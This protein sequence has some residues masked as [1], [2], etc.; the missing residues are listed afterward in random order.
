MAEQTGAEADNTD[1]EDHGTP[2][3]PNGADLISLPVGTDGDKVAVYWA[4]NPNNEE[5]KQAYVMIHGKMKDGNAY[6]TTMNDILT[7][8][9]EDNYPGVDENAIVV[10]PQFYSA[11]LNSGQYK[12]DELAWDDVNAWQAGEAAIHPANAKESSFDVL[13]AFVNE[14]N[15]KTKYPAMETLVFVGHGGGGQLMTRYAIV[16]KDAPA[17]LRMRWIVGDPSSQPY[18]TEDRPSVDSGEK[19]PTKD[20]CP[21]Y[22][23]WR[24]GFTNF[25][26]TLED[27]LKTPQD[28]F[29]QTIKRD[30][31][32]VVGNDD[33]ESGGDQYCMAVM[34]GG[35]PRRD[36]NLIWWRYL[37]TLARTAEDLT[38]FPGSFENLPDWSNISLNLIQHRLTVVEDAG[39]SADEVFG[40][41]VGRAVLFQDDATTLP[42]GWRPNGWNPNGNGRKVA[43]LQP[44]N[45]SSSSKSS[46]SAS[47]EEDSNTTS[48]ATLLVPP[49][50]AAIVISM[51]VAT[52]F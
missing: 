52:L 13:D 17:G 4:A 9:L 47:Q 15:D 27:G 49:T 42:T 8:A 43:A 11:K 46:S 35:T 21:L 33:T 30:V 41:D 32:Y 22:N 34:Q 3:V 19:L 48:P 45:N 14:F 26:G 23:T 5:A 51:A 29:A 44:N 39:H 2:D 1:G 7:S 10:A 24:Y 18:F 28:Y 50:L 40:S 12:D 6:W 37:N 36:R 38:G 20:D 31:R 25:S 16:G